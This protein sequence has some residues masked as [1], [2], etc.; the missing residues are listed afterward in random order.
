[1]T[2]RK[3]EFRL[4]DAPPL[5]GT[6]AEI[7]RIGYVVERKVI[8]YACELLERTYSYSVGAVAD[9]VSSWFSQKNRWN[10]IR[11]GIC[12]AAAQIALM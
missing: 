2:K 4:N 9:E 1:M 10:T 11:N 12:I 6:L 5:V 3:F 8:E 7:G